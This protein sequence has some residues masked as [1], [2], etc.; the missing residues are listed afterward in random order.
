MKI[1]KRNLK[2]PVWDGNNIKNKILLIYSEQGYG[3]TI[4][5]IRFI[6]SIEKLDICLIFAF[7]KDLHKLIQTFPNLPFWKII[8]NL[9]IN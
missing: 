2:T 6:K 9:N 8:L 7:T 5:F 3:D 4:Q 1:K